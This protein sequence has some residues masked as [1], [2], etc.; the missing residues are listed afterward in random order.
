MS[1]F[2]ETL[3]VKIQMNVDMISQ[4]LNLWNKQ[5]QNFAAQVKESHKH[6][7]I[8]LKEDDLLPEFVKNED[9][10]AKEMIENMRKLIF[11]IN[12]EPRHHEMKPVENKGVLIEN[13]MSIK[14]Q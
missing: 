6:S 4:D 2:D 10:T 9:K 3:R 14:D 13:I 1:C 12:T 8:Q 5:Q 7:A 11:R